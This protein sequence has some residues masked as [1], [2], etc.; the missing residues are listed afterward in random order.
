[1]ISVIIVN[2]R[3]PD[4]LLR[5][6][7]SLK[8][9]PPRSGPPELIVVDNASGDDSVARLR[10][11]HPDVRV[12]ESPD[13][14]GFAAGVNLGL[15]AASGSHLLV[16]NPDIVVHP[17]SIDALVDFLA[18]HPKAGLVAAKLLN[19]DGTLQ[20][21]CR[22]RYTLKTILLRRTPLGRLFPNDPTVRE[23][24]MVD[25]DHATPR[26]V[27]WVAGACMMVRREALDEVGP[28]DE[29]YF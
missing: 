25:Y 24:L 26:N 10:A 13:N 18:A 20:P 17:G 1:M 22:T 3:T 27:D 11:A 9:Y 16:L 7:E 8:A 14:R 21:T 4:D 28:M 5:L 23:H 6:L 15:A 12:I 29:R 19:P 2:Y